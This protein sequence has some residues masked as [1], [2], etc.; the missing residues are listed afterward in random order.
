[1]KMDVEKAAHNF[2]RSQLLQPE[3]AKIMHPTV[4]SKVTHK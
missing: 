3:G 2:E 1:M 4:I